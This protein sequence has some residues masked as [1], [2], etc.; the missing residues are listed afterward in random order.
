MENPGY[1]KISQV[2]RCQGVTCEYIPM[3]FQGLSV[4]ALRDSKVTVLHISPGH[5]FPTGIVMPIKR[6]QEL[7]C[8][9]KER[10]GRYIIEDDYDSELRFQGR[11]IQTLQSIDDEE[12]VIYINTFSKTMT[13]SIRISYIVLPRHLMERYQAKL[14]FYACTVPSFEQ[15]T[16]ARFIRE[17]YFEQ[18]INRMRNYY[19]TLRD[20][21]VQ[22]I[23]DS[24]LRGRMLIQEQNSGLHFLLQVKTRKSDD[25]I[26]LCA[27]RQGIR[28]D[29]LSQY[30]EGT[31]REYEHCLVINYS[32]VDR[33]RIQEGIR[34]LERI[35][36]DEE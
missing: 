11:P 36:Q 1:R 15:Y 7:L 24:R 9:A 12:K 16:L 35:F 31:G 20:E 6:R 28:L 29:C 30:Y 25:E 14:S 23:E 2:Y 19:R 22:A 3:D 21:M 18:H 4:K 13:P 10:G 34:R 27:Q 32:G 17:G 26:R 33:K 5:H 8:W